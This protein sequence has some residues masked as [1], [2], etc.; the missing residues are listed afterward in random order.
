MVDIGMID[1][2][3]LIIDNCRNIDCSIDCWSWLVMVDWWLMLV[4]FTRTRPWISWL[5]PSARRQERYSESELRK[6]LNDNITERKIDAMKSLGSHGGTCGDPRSDNGGATTNW[7]W[8]ASP[9]DAKFGDVQVSA[10]KSTVRSRFSG[11]RYNCPY[12]YAWSKLWIMRLGFINPNQFDF[13]LKLTFMVHE[14]KIHPI[15]SWGLWWT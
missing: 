9:N 11:D 12:I 14:I 13:H 10:V 15:G 6:A 1:I 3:I 5:R 4:N 7:Q 8:L 2:D